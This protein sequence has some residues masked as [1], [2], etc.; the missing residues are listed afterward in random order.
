MEESISVVKNVQIMSPERSKDKRVSRLRGLVIEFET[1]ESIHSKTVI[2]LALNDTL[3]PFNVKEVE[4]I[5]NGSLLGRAVECGYWAHKLTKKIENG[6]M[7]IRDLMGK[8]IT[9]VTDKERLAQINEESC[10]C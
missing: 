10:W 8:P 5:E 7:D 3:K 4:I 1:K 6:E 9:I 2:E